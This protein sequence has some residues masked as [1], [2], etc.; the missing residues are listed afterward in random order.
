MQAGG[1]PLRRSE[2]A[3]VHGAPWGTA[4]PVGVSRLIPANLRG[5]SFDIEARVGRALESHR[6]RLGPSPYPPLLPWT[7]SARFLA[8]RWFRWLGRTG[9]LPEEVA[10][11]LSDLA[12]T[13]EQHPEVDLAATAARPEWDGVHEL[14]RVIGAWSH[15]GA[16]LADAFLHEEG[17][18]TVG[19]ELRIDLRDRAADFGEAVA[20][21]LELRA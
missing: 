7:V 19:I 4:F 15:E 11:R 6:I 5:T 14:A 10:A 1:R 21:A 17:V 3:V 18:F 12:W 16:D 2:A 13:D 8:D 20:D 9:R